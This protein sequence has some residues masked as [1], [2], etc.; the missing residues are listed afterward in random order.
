VSIR[1][2]AGPRRPVATGVRLAEVVTHPG[3]LALMREKPFSEVFWI[4]NASA[5]PFSSRKRFALVLEVPV[6][7]PPPPIQEPPAAHGA[8]ICFSGQ[9]RAQE[10][11][12]RSAAQHVVE[13]LGIDVFGV[14]SLVLGKGLHKEGQEQAEERF[15]S[16]FFV[17]QSSGVCARS[18]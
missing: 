15:R 18:L 11:V 4:H 10:R 17:C 13:H 1:L 9:W 16:F 7:L 8:A 14:F 3:T 12:A 6:S 5:L 2:A